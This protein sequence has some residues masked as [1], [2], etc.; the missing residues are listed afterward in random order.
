LEGISIKS[1]K[2]KVGIK[3]IDS[4]L[5][6]AIYGAMDLIEWKKQIKKG[7]QIVVKPNMGN[8]TYIPGVITNPDVL[9]HVVSRLRDYAEDVIVGESDGIR[10]SC[11]EAFAKTNFKAIVE[12]AG[13]RVINFSNDKQIPV[14]IS[15]F[16][17]DEVLLPKSIVDAD[18]FV[19]IPLV[20]THEATTLTCGIKNQW[21]CIADRNR[22]L[23]HH[24]LHKVL[25]DVNLAIKPDLIVTD[26]TICMEGNGPIHGPSKELN[27]I[28][29]SNNVLANDI[30]VSRIAKFD[31][32]TIEYLTNACKIGLGPNNISEIEILG[33]SLK[34][35]NDFFLAPP[36]LD[37]VANAMSL[38]YRSKF[39]THV[40]FVSPFFGIMN[41]VAWLY[42][43]FYGKKKRT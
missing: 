19:S 16:F 33:E 29:C 26:G 24:H 15:G 23:F 36:K 4:D 40:V 42:R 9:Y 14:K 37:L 18:S 1:G 38:I 28:I 30:V 6:S 41:R 39:L 31:E 3:K 20:K 34:N 32:N 5:Q 22:I 21:G 11:D 17:W 2:F 13:G 25:V 35:F 8:L 43:G 7:G 27:L 12:K 10:Y